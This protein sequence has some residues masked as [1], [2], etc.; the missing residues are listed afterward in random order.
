MVEHLTDKG[1]SMEIKQG[2]ISNANPDKFTHACVRCGCRNELQS[3]AHR[4]NNENT[5]RGFIFVCCDCAPIIAEATVTLS[6]FPD[7][8]SERDRL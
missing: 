3:F 8:G 7:K 1:G 2:T 6:V 5:I 4:H